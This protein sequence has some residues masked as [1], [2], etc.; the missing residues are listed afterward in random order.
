MREKFLVF[1]SPRIEQPEIDEVVQVLESGWLGTGPRVQQFEKDFAAYKG[2]PH[3]AALFS[4]TAGLHLSCLALNLKPSD[5]VITTPMTF[6][7]SA[8]A[9][10]HSGATPVIAD[11]DPVSWNIDPSALEKK[12][13]PKTKALMLVHFAGRMCDMDPIMEI[14]RK[15]NLSVIEDCAH[16]IETT[17]KGKK[18]GTFGDFGVFSFYSTKNLAT[19]EGGMVLSNS[20]EQIARIKVLGLHGMSRDAWKRFSDSGYKH[21][22]VEE[23]GFKYNMMDLQAAL[24]IHQLKRI[25]DYAVIRKNIWN[26]YMTE[27]KELPI[28]LPAAIEP[29]TT[30]AY[31]LFQIRINEEKA[32]LTRDQFLDEITKHKIGVG[33]HYLSLPEHP[34][35]K[36]TFGW[37]PDDYPHARD[38]GRESVS[39]PISAKLSDQDVTD[40][41]AAVRAVLKR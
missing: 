11:I 13:T 8:N 38:L 1:G 40:V 39:L 37:N 27:L 15:H 2:M 12:I 22:Y 31:H 29:N 18:A 25:E 23:A 7:A 24:G 35:Y 17:Y 6:C 26:R 16:A 9:I 4:N 5:E 20:A 34:Y 30:H 28:G 32:G 21:Y 41:I 33:V 14:A 10:I 3:A 19:G 36:R